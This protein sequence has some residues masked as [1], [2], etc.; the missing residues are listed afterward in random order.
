M[1]QGV[2]DG[3]LSLQPFGSLL[4]WCR[5]NPWPRNFHMLQ[6]WSNKKKKSNNNNPCLAAL[7]VYLLFRKH[8]YLENTPK[9]LF[10]FLL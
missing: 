6:A 10:I 1:V 9:T 4:L 8:Q 7:S 3:E 2:K 5:F